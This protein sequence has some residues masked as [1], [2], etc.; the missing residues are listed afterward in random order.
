MTVSATSVRPSASPAVGSLKS[1]S[2]GSTL[3]SGWAASKC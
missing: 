1:Y 2:T 3:M